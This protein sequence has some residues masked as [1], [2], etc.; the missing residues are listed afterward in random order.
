MFASVY[1]VRENISFIIF[2]EYKV[3]ELSFFFIFEF[4]DEFI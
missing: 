4:E 1:K 3:K 2:S